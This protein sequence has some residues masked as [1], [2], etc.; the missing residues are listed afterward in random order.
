MS[1]ASREENTILFVKFKVSE[2]F[3]NVNLNQIVTNN[4][5]CSEK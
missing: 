3:F 2:N 1:I 4:S 5:N